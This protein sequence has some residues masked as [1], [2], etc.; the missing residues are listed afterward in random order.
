LTDDRY[1]D[2]QPAWSAD[3]RRLAW[4][5][6]R[7][8]RTDLETLTYGP[9]QIALV[10]LPGGGT[11]A[12]R[13]QTVTLLPLFP[14]G[15]HTN[16]Q[17]SP[18][19]RS[20]YL[21]ADPDG[22]RNLYVRRL[23]GP[24][25]ITRLTNL[26]TGVAGITDLSPALSVA[27]R[28]GAVAFSA[29]L[30]SG[31]LLY[32]LTPDRARSE[33]VDPVELTSTSAATLPP[34]ARSERSTVQAYLGTPRSAPEEPTTR[35]T[36]YRSRFSLLD[37]G[38]P[39]VGAAVDTTYGLGLG[40]AM[41]AY[42]GDTLG[43]QQLGV[44]LQGAVSSE[45]F[46]NSLGVAATYLNQ[47]HR[48]N[49]GASGGRVPYIT[50]STAVGQTVVDVDG[51]PVTTD[52]V[53]QLREKV[54]IEQVGLFSQY[55]FSQSRRF[56]VGGYFTRQ[57]IDRE[58]ETALVL[59]DSVLDSN[60]QGLESPPDLD[61]GQGYVAYV[62][63]TAAFAFTSPVAGTRFRL[64]AGT[65]AGT[66]R[67]QTALADFRHYVPFRPASFAVRALH[68]GRYGGDA[69]SDLLAPLFL[70]RETLVRGYA[71]D[72]FSASE[73]TTTTGSSCPEFDR[74][75]GDRLGVV[76]LELRLQVLGGGGYGLA[77]LP[78]LPLELVGFVD[79]GAAW[80]ENTTVKLEFD[81][82]SVERVPVVSAGIAAR[83]LVA[84]Y[85]PI[86]VYAAHPLQR[87]DQNVVYGFLIT[88]G[89]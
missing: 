24:V 51:T 34:Q 52:V 56:E 70:G 40:G 28:S 7:G 85:L 16:P 12:S 78:Y 42:F 55:P 14:D 80:D 49:W 84:G 3:G 63:D 30:N 77:A 44:S 13:L 88:P 36:A 5:T 8:P 67:F 53:Q 2:L 64:E 35:P 71:E 66:L 22:V 47:A 19:G 69:T 61:L 72:S 41:S 26:S 68:Y 46:G 23:D 48:W 37:I 58:V 60:V 18:D 9:T 73:C 17:F 81:R 54:V 38:P 6:D 59:G 1:A 10:D 33:R 15:N 87:P 29:Y 50:A 75:T 20:L 83:V 57:S 74:L 21:L 27:A 82:D 43:R 89:W 65:T 32:T 45:S 4:T 31:H 39:V 79:V 62:R 86:E 11:G 25:T 76:N